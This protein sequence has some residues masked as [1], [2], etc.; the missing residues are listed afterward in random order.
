MIL[1][2]GIHDCSWR[3]V[4]M[5][6]LKRYTLYILNIID[7]VSI[8]LS[9][10]FSFWIRFRMFD[11][12]IHPRMFQGE[13]AV[14]L[15]TAFLS[16]ILYNIFFLY[17][18]KSFL[19]RSIAEEA[20]QTFKMSAAVF[21]FVLIYINFAKVGEYYSRFFELLFGTLLFVIAFFLRSTAK[22]YLVPAMKKTREMEQL[23]VISSY[24][25]AEETIRELNDSN[26][27]RYS[28]FGIVITDRDIKE[29]E[30]FGVK[31]ASS[32][33]DFMKKLPEDFSSVLLV[34][35][36]ENYSQIQ[37]MMSAFHKQGKAVYVK[38]A[39]YGFS[40]NFRQLDVLGECP[41]VAYRV[42][43]PMPKRKAVFRRILNLIASILLLPFFLIVTLIVWVFTEI[44]SPG[45][46][47]V[48][49][50]RVGK[51]N[52]R[53][54][55]LRYRLYRIDA[56]QRMEEGLSPFTL[57][58]KFL[59]RTH[60]DGLPM[61]LNVVS[62]EMAFVGPE[63]QS[64]P[65]FLNLSPEEK[66]LMTITPGVTGYWSYEK[67]HAEIIRNEKEYLEHWNLGKEIS[68]LL[69]T[70]FRY[71][72]FQSQRKQDR[73]FWA[74]ESA[75][76]KEEFNSRKPLEYE[77]SAYAPVRGARY[78]AYQ[79]VKRVFDIVLSSAGIIILSPLLLFLA[80]AVILNDGGMPIYSHRR[81]GKNGKRIRIYKFRS[82]RT[83]AGDLEKLLTP[84]QLEQYRTEFKIDNDPRI[85]KIGNFIRKTSLDELPQLFN[86]LG[87][88]LS[89][90]GPRPI[91]EEETK[92]Y[93][94]D[95]A[96]LLSVKPGLTGY[97]Q[98]Y[99]RNEAGYE[100]GERQAMEM[101]YIDHQSLWLD[102][103]ILFKTFSSVLQRKGAK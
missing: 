100:T 94:K 11:P 70:S 41:V 40:S 79:I 91:V 10:F 63:C 2:C 73:Y 26:D 32:G 66:N 93:G 21:L 30:I 88:S 86:I 103:R 37:K 18:E 15:I 23:L 87:G 54:Y 59:E 55:Q 29:K 71:L 33:T 28:I 101:Y 19:S 80:A 31:V 52:R 14:F 61:L 84:E 102:I 5:S 49:R 69:N 68:V 65:A 12:G 89:I 8:F 75:F 9:F 82:M 27:W 67:S 4:Q 51:N 22:K 50:A 72:I 58:G 62:G 56:E 83:D 45:R 38:I 57:I 76:A 24:S 60:L 81:I 34:Q 20:F 13:Y 25:D 48:T 35:K 47:F 98:A 78:I 39:E 6:N 3:V 99:A 16:Y 85:T 36:P 1:A 17:N 43:V 90:V 77:H 92:I 53:F 64:L 44:E 96:K 95:I 42:F 74:E 97:W 46:L 7:A